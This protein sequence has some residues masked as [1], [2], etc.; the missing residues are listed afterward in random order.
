MGDLEQLLMSL[1]DDEAEYVLHLSP[2]LFWQW[3]ERKKEEV[4]A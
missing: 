1:D 3:Y 4:A 2:E